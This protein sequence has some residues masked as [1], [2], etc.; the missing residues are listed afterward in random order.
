MFNVKY[1]AVALVT[2]P[3]I[4]VAEGSNVALSY[5][6]MDDSSWRKLDIS[7]V[8]NIA[9]NFA[10]QTDF[11]YLED[12]DDGSSNWGGMLHLL[13]SVN[14]NITVG[15]NYGTSSEDGED[16]NQNGI[17]VKY[18]AQSWELEAARSVE[19]DDAKWNQVSALYRIEDQWSLEV[20]ALE[21]DG[22]DTVN[23]TG[24][25]HYQL[26]NGPKVSAS[27]T[28]AGSSNDNDEP[29]DGVFGIAVSMDLGSGKVMK[30]RDY[31]T[32]W[33]F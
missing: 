10:V 6:D 23:V 14:D 3:S 16:Y 1:L 33:W 19:V 24:T 18:T 4:S 15:L 17:E 12:D 32:N 9:G 2:L 28:R 11:T 26:D 29:A 13:Y 31:L 5:Y 25:V 20:D 21:R 22:D 7:N 27:Y 30:H 8:I